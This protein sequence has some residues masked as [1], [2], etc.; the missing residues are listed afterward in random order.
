MGIQRV[1]AVQ[2]EALFVGAPP[3]R[4]ETP[5]WLGS[6]GRVKYRSAEEIGVAGK[7]TQSILAAN[8]LVAADGV[9]VFDLPVSPLSVVLLHVSP[10]NDTATIANHRLLSSLL[11]AVDNVTVSFRGGAF[12]ALS[13]ADLAVLC[14]L[15]HRWA[16]WQSN[17]V[18]T[19]NDRRSLV[20]PVPFGRRAF[21]AKECFPATKKGELQM[22]VTWDIADTGYDGL[23]VSVETIEL[24]GATPE[25]VQKVTTLARTLAAT[26]Q[27]EIDLPI[28]N[29][30]RAVLLF[31]TTSYAGATPAPTLGQVQL[32]KDN[33][34]QYVSASD[35]EVLRGVLGLQ[36]VPFPPDVR[37][38]HSGTYTTTVAGDSLEPEVG[39]S[40]DA[41]YAL[42]DLDPLRDDSFGM[43]TEGAGR[44]HVR[45]D[46]EA[47]NAVRV[48]PIERV[49]SGVFLES[50]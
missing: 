43:E 33:V 12:I 2:A 21:D 17:A 23:R 3:A 29:F 44:V 35:F 41:C 46:A 25:Y 50:A 31:G 24:P 47:A 30:L 1:E 42:M 14:M 34:Q 49:K 45:I 18:E 27:N 5:A 4:V 11:S 36:G 37:H 20:L 32:L 10:L 15:W 26:G 6:S 7:Y 28:G 8:Q 40:L 39:L 48:I 38:I 13:G 19:D 22:S 9:Q 16:L